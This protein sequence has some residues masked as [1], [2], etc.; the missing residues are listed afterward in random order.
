[1]HFCF[2]D[3]KG[4]SA[5]WTL[6]NHVAQRLLTDGHRV[7]YCMMADQPGASS[8][9]GPLE[10][11]V[12]EIEV[13]RK[14]VPWDVWKQERAFAKTFKRILRQ[15]LP[16]VVHTNF[17]LPG[18]VAR[19]T[20][21]LLGVPLVVTTCHELFG[22]LNAYLRYASRRTAKHANCTTYVSKTVAKSYGFLEQLED[23]D[24]HCL[25][26]NGIAIAQIELHAQQAIE[27]VP[28]QIISIGRLVPEKKPLTDH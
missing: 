13:P 26:Y 23:A 25:I 14:R 22:S 12:H 9:D 3:R 15:D 18:N 1:M 7:T 24:Q 10:V 11:Q 16:D 4:P 28:Q 2:T 19:K 6:V 27:A 17:C 5:I 20:S 8:V 21:S